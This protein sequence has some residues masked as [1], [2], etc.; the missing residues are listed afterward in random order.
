MPTRASPSARASWRPSRAYQSSARPTRPKGTLSAD[1]AASSLFPGPVARLFY[2]SLAR[3]ASFF[4]L[5]LKR[6]RLGLP[7]RYEERTSQRLRQP[8]DLGEPL[9]L[10]TLL[11][12]A[13]RAETASKPGGPLERLAREAAGQGG[14]GCLVELAGVKGF[15]RAL[16]KA[17][18]EYAGDFGLLNDM[19]RCSIIC[20]KF[21]ALTEVLR[22]IVEDAQVWARDDAQLPSFEL[23][24]AKD[25]LSPSFDAEGLG[26]YRYVLLVGRLDLG[27]EF[28]NVEVQVGPPTQPAAPFFSATGPHLPLTVAASIRMH[29]CTS[30]ASSSCA[31]RFTRYTRGGGRSAR[32]TMPWRRTRAS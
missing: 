19:A 18:L 9:L 28:L 23:L 16:H 25:R 24:T 30:S 17:H 27:G 14:P 15:R 8:G 4:F 5:Q 32:P 12:L 1:P 20:P 26:M 13:Q 2:W 31:R 3:D 22:W 6:P 29:R 21:S 10:R 7:R 11:F